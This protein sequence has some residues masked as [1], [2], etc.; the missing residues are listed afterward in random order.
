MNDQKTN[1]TRFSPLY[2][3]MYQLTMGQAYF[4]KG[5]HE[6]PASFDYF[7]RK[8][9]FEGGYVLF[10][11]LGNLLEALKELR[12]KEA[13]IDYLHIHDFHP[14]YI[15]YLKDFQFKGNVAGMQEGEVVFP[16][17]PILRV[18]GGLLE[19]QLVESM[20]LNLLNFQSLIA[21]K[22]N[23]IK[24]SAGKRIL[25]DFGLRRAQGSGGMHASRAAIIGG[26]DNTSNV[27]A[28]REYNIEPSGTMAHSFIESHENELE[29]FR[30]YAV[31][32]P[33]NCV[34][35]VDTYNT[36][37]SGLPNAITVGKELQKKGHDLAGIRL[38]SGDLA[39]LSKKART[40]L[41][42]AGLNNTKIVV[43]NQLDE[44][45]IK[46]L[47]EQSAPIDVFGVGTSMIT[48]KPDAALDGVYKLS[49]ADKKPRLKISENVQ[50]ITL[51]G[52]KK[53]LRYFNEDGQF[54]ADCIAMHDEL[55]PEIMIHPFEK[56]KSMTLKGFPYEDVFHYHMEKG[57]LTYKLPS[58][59]EI[60]EKGAERLSLLPDEHK[61]FDFPHI[62]K[63]GVSKKLQK[64]QSEIITNM[65]KG[66]L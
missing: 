25:T 17:E 51:P 66:V 24:N 55:Q 20:L 27:F 46:S 43:S 58:V 54:Y 60:R 9:P 21:T 44:H 56:E 39:Y 6:S 41:D 47:I 64:L 19:V 37:K 57:Q 11:G 52:K 50:K 13:D 18:E 31:N 32:Y 59:F 29:A 23:R 62:Y 53:V 3:D 30:D 22:A 5:R 40:M 45:L 33:D 42:K 35:L 7:F 36:L 28:A 49:F 61:R 48:G 10:A 38:D 63:V 2:T 26:F 12:F 1:I 16:V 65:Q 4:M 14:D 15:E 34:L 8:L